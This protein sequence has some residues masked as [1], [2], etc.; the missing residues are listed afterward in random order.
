MLQKEAY[1]LSVFATLA[2]MNTCADL[3]SIHESNT[4]A[5]FNVFPNSTFKSCVLY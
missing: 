3:V 1:L 4:K 5:S 2:F